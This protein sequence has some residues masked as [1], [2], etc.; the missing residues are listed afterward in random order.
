MDPLQVISRSIMVCGHVRTQGLLDTFDQLINDILELKTSFFFFSGE[1]SSF[2]ETHRGSTIL[3]C[4][5]G[6]GIYCAILCHS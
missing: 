6:L 1:T 3:Q 2:F 5:V 4:P